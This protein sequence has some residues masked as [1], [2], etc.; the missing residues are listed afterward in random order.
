MHSNNRL[1]IPTY[2][3]IQFC[4]VI[5]KHNNFLSGCSWDC[6][7]EDEGTR[8]LERI[9]NLSLR[10]QSVTS[11]RT[12]IF[13]NGEINQPVIAYTFFEFFDACVSVHHI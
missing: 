2:K 1:F 11:R 7:P 10:E 3:H 8:I 9:R 13:Q 12:R 4:Y 5:G 6:Y